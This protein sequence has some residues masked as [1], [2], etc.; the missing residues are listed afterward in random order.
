MHIY[1]QWRESLPYYE[2]GDLYRMQFEIQ[3]A[4]VEEETSDLQDQIDELRRAINESR[5]IQKLELLQDPVEDE[6]GEEEGEE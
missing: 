1:V 4:I 2:I 5:A 6:E 3:S